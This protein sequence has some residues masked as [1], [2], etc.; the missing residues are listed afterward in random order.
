[1]KTSLKEICDIV[2]AI[3]FIY[4]EV[5][6]ENNLV[7]QSVLISSNW[8]GMECEKNPSCMRMPISWWYTDIYGVII[9]YIT[10]HSDPKITYLILEL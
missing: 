7:L 1:M 2:L 8:S 5:L 9:W 10:D 4:L 6:F 3:V